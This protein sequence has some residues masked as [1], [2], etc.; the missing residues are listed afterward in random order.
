MRNEASLEGDM[1]ASEDLGFLLSWD[2]LQHVYMQMREEDK[3]LQ[4]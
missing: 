3:W 4:K 1:G 2:I